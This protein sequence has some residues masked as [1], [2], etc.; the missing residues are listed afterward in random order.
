M[1]RR[2]L[3]T[4]HA[5]RQTVT[6]T[7]RDGRTVR[8]PAESADPYE[9]AP[10]RHQAGRVEAIRARCEAATPGPWED[11]DYNRDCPGRDTWLG[12]INGAFEITTEHVTIGRVKYS[13]LPH[14]E[15]VANARFIAHAR[16]DIPWLLARITELETALAAARSLDPERG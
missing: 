9:L 10:D 13:A 12:V 6:M 7:D 11:I 14:P 1:G 3:S 16:A 15:N 5:H 2:Y 4:V 8:F